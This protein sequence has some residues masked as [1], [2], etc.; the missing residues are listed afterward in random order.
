MSPLRGSRMRFWFAWLKTRAVL[1]VVLTCPLGIA[2][3]MGFIAND[4]PRKGTH[5]DR[6]WVRYILSGMELRFTPTEEDVCALSRISPARGWYKFLFLLLLA[7]LFL[8]GAY[9]VDHGFVV[10]GWVWLA[11]SVAVGIG[12]YEVPRFQTRRAFQRSPSAQGEIVYTLDEKGVTASFSTGRSQM[13]WR[14]FVK[15]QGDRKLLSPVSF[16]VPIL[17]DSKTR[18]LAGAGRRTVQLPENPHH[19]YNIAISLAIKGDITT[20]PPEPTRLGYLTSRHCSSKLPIRQQRLVIRLQL[21]NRLLHLEILRA[22]HES[23]VA[24]L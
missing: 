1:R 12:M 3:D 2:Y 13:E 16:C 15:C 11:L 6:S 7:V 10:A 23:G 14:A 4:C 18:N 5:I 9:L 22:A 21:P 8:V 24:H 17:V 19:A 20:N